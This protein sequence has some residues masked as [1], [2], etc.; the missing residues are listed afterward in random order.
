MP[1]FARTKSQLVMLP[2]QLEFSLFSKPIFTSVKKIRAERREF[3]DKAMLRGERKKG[4][5]E[6]GRERKRE[7]IITSCKSSISE[8]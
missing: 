4:Q 8:L 1:N 2:G 7:R 6:G 3:R 5:R